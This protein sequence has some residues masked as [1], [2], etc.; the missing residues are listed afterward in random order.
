MQKNYAIVTGASSGIGYQ[1]A[2][3]L[4]AKGYPLILVA[5]RAD[6]LAAFKTELVQKYGIAVEV[7]VLDLSAADA[8]TVLHQKTAAFDVE[9]LV[10]NAGFG[11]QANVAE[12]EMARTAEMIALNI[13]TLTHLTQLYAHDFIQKK[14]GKILQVASAAALL[15]TPYL[16]A[17]AA[18]KS[19]VRHF[20]DALAHE[21]RN[22]PV[23]VTTLMPGFTATEFGH[24]ADVSMPK[25]LIATQTTAR[26][27]A[28]A[29]VNGMLAGKQSVIPGWFTSMNAFFI[30]IAPRKLVTFLTGY[31][32]EKAV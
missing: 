8:A 28:E 27:V 12:Q 21:L 1:I 25:L 22:T 29:G 2:D 4:A 17:Y 6:R 10:N 26:E 30:S 20:S 16:A 13:T 18:T 11:F 23:T 14:R 15:P 9:I 32:I 19:Y 31:L 7:V 5:R 3:V 24:V